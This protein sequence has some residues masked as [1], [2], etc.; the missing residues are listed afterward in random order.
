M[1]KLLLPL[2]ILALLLSATDLWA[3]PPKP[4]AVIS[5]ARYEALMDDVKFLGKLADTPEMAVMVDPKGDDFTGYGFLPVSDLKKL[6][7][8]IEPLVKSVEKLDGGV[9]KLTSED[10]QVAYVQEKGGWAF[11]ADDPKMFADVPADPLKILGGLEKQYDL[12]VRFHPGNLPAVLRDQALEAA[13]VAK[14]LAKSPD[15]D[16]VTVTAKAVRNGVHYHLEV[17]PG[18]LR[19]FGRLVAEAQAEEEQ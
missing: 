19:L 6:I 15:Q 16:H 10:G 7:K 17:E 4:V 18:L 8:A 1:K 3:K 14:L 13:K 12:A 5:F 2:V 9:F 11:V